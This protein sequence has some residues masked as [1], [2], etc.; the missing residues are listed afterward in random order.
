VEG[1]ASSEPCLWTDRVRVNGLPEGLGKDLGAFPT[2]TSYAGASSYPHVT[3]PDVQP[4]GEAQGD[5]QKA[6]GRHALVPWLA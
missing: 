5:L 6:C 3:E 4:Q 2:L 1:S